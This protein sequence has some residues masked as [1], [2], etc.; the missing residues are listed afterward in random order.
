M[1]VDTRFVLPVYALIEPVGSFCPESVLR[2]ALQRGIRSQQAAEAVAALKQQVSGR[3]DHLAELVPRAGEEAMAMGA[4]VAAGEEAGWLQRR[5]SPPKS[6]PARFN[7][8]LHGR[9]QPPPLPL[10]QQQGRQTASGAGEVSQ[11]AGSADGDSTEGLG[12]WIARLR[13]GQWRMVMG[14]GAGGA[15]AAGAALSSSS[16]MARPLGWE[17]N[18]L[19]ALVGE[20]HRTSLKRVSLQ[21]TSMTAAA[22]AAAATAAESDVGRDVAGSS[23]SSTSGVS[24]AVGGGAAMALAQAAEVATA[25]SEERAAADEDNV[26]ISASDVQLLSEVVIK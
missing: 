7:V 19:S 15:V 5:Q 6:P 1:D 4:G 18:T 20:L 24:G 25:T 9:R 3:Y 10:A 21:R 14:R 17:E 26:A 11:A 2:K 12:G 22:T 8:L 23:A 16:S 13:R